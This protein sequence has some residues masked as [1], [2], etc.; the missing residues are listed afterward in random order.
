MKTFS[1]AFNDNDFN[2]EQRAAFAKVICFNYQQ[3][4]KTPINVVLFAVQSQYPEFIKAAFVTFSS[5]NMHNMLF[6]KDEQGQ[7][8]M[9]LASSSH[10]VFGVI[11]HYCSEI[12]HASAFTGIG[13]FLIP[14]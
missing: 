13:F 8:L 14:Q 1:K 10:E 11:K 2:H 9:D 3:V 5:K 12:Q 7:N 4:F 6:T